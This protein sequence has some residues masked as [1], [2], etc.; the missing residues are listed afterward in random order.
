MTIEEK[1][2]AYDEALERAIIAHKDEDRHLKATLEGIFPE[3][4]KYEDEWMCNIAI[5]ACKYMMENFENSTKQYEEAISWLEKQGEKKPAWSEED[6]LK[7]KEIE[8]AYTN[9]CHGYT[10]DTIL[11]WLKSLKQRIGG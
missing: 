5:N 4:K 6:E 10:Q 7:I 1:S 3:L 11:D 8:E 9:Y 2:K